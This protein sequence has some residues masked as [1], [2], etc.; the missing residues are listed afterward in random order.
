MRSAL[1]HRLRPV[2]ASSR[3]GKTS[4]IE[5][6]VFH[7]PLPLMENRNRVVTRDEIIE[8]IGKSRNH[9][10]FGELESHQVA[11]RGVGEDGKLQSHPDR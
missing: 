3:P 6:Q 10:G 1:P 7:L 2:R 9:L 11:R 8:K 5:P 4:R